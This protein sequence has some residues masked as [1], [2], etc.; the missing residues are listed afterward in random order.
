MGIEKL[1]PEDV[2]QAVDAAEAGDFGKLRSLCDL[3]LA[4]GATWRDISRRFLFK[5]DAV[6]DTGD[7]GMRAR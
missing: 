7:P 6:R 5:R 4:N 1:T 2:R 3:T